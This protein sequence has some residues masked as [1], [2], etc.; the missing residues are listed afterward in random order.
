MKKL[1]LLPILLIAIT[2]ISCETKAPEKP[3]QTDEEAIAAVEEVVQKLFDEVWAGYDETAITK[4]QTDD[5]LL[6]EHGEV[7][8]N[9]TIANWCINAKTRVNNT[10]RINNFERIDARVNG[11]KLWLAYHNIGTFKRD[12]LTYNRGWL[13]SV[14]AVKQDS[15]WKLEL[16]HST[17][18]PVE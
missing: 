3:Q 14:V 11:D 2:T 16:M 17:R 12:T 6:L 9:D 15:I 5:F 18:M 10:E 1:L 7:W 8:N 13:E 4:Y